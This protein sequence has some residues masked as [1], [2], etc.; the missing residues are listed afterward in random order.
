MT[1]L[2]GWAPCGQKL[3]AKVP[4]GRKD[5]LDGVEVRAVRRQ[6]L[7]DFPMRHRVWE[8]RAR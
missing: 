6:G 8:E 7:S 5:L 1:R 2:H 3:L 4:Q